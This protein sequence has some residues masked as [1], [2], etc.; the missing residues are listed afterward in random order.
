MSKK[1]IPYRRLLTISNVPVTAY[2]AQGASRGSWFKDWDKDALAM[3]T[4]A[5]ADESNDFAGFKF[6]ITLN[7]RFGGWL[8]KKIARP[9]VYQENPA[10]S[11]P[12][13]NSISKSSPLKTTFKMLAGL[14]MYPIYSNRLKAFLKTFRPEI[15]FSTVADC[16]GARLVR[17]IANKL[18]IPYIIQQEDNW[19]VSD[20]KGLIK[21]LAYCIRKHCLKQ[22]LKGA[23]KR[24]VICPSMKDYFEELFCLPF[25]SLFC[26]DEPSRF[27]NLFCMTRIKRQSFYILATAAQA[28]AGNI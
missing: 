1:S 13:S 15:I 9:A 2:S 24:Y 8:F 27:L 26:A 10:Q 19:L 4:F 20:A 6:D 23:S 28:E 25:E 16:Y 22:S 21:P 12:E 17:F 3:M 5:K 14:F 7:E 11:I 18:H